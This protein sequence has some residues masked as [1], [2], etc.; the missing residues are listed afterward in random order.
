MPP[1]CGCSLTKDPFSAIQQNDLF[2]L[3]ITDP[4]LF[5]NRGW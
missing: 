2:N 4:S 3:F 5:Y 1:E